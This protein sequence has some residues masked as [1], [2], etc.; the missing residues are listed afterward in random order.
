MM[1]AA[2]RRLLDAFPSA[3]IGR[4][5]DQSDERDRVRL[6]FRPVVWPRDRASLAGVLGARVIDRYADVLGMTPDSAVDAV[7]DV[8][9]WSY[10]DQWGP[11]AIERAADRCAQRRR[12]GVPTVFMPQS[13][14]PFDEPESRTALRRL[15]EGAALVFARDEDSLA[16]LERVLGERP[17]VVLGTDYS[18]DV[19]PAPV[20]PLGETEYVCIVPNM[21]VVKGAGARERADYVDL[22]TTAARWA[23]ARRWEPVVLTH[24]AGQDDELADA[25]AAG[26]TGG[27][28]LGRY[29]SDDPRELKAV[30]GRAQLVIGSRFHAL[31]SALARGVPAIGLGWAP[32]YAGLF[33]QHRCREMLLYAPWR[34]DALLSVLG[35]LASDEGRTELQDRIRTGHVAASAR[36]DEMWTQAMG[37]IRGS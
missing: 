6:G 11:K 15:G 22:L 33:E 14:G 31:A 30:L 2:Q 18:I 1:L 19:E 36:V 24:T 8:S 7:L 32:K 28:R 20:N 27:E 21:R 37:A 35:P 16:N 34:E 13:W 12:R 4:R 23:R 10:G 26:W 29:F 3:V 5:V 25:I 9:G 17:D